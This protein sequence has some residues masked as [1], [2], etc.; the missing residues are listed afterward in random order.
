MR[1]FTVDQS[2]KMVEEVFNRYV[3]PIVKN[4]LLGEIPQ[5]ILTIHRRGTKD[6]D[7]LAQIRWKETN[8]TSLFRCDVYMDDI[9]RLCRDSRLYLQTEDIFP[10]ILLYFIMH[11]VYQ[12]Q[13][14]D[15]TSDLVTDY[16]SMMLKA[17][18]Q[19]SMYIMEKLSAKTG[20]KRSVVD[21]L[22]TYTAYMLKPN[23]DT[24]VNLRLAQRKYQRFATELWPMAYPVA[25]L[26][27]GHTCMIDSE[28]LMHIERLKQMKE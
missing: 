14:N 28:G 15:F 26:R 27:R 5:L 11:P 2:V 17:S 10:V 9:Y 25:A 1:T 18:E 4:Y 23:E 12:S 3:E 22:T 7:W 20:Y 13:Y 19:T 16:D 24:L 8:T 6:K 21:V